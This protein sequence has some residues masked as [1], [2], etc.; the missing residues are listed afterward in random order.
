MYKRMPYG[1]NYASAMGRRRQRNSDISVYAWLLA[2]VGAAPAVFLWRDPHW[3][4]LCAAF[5]AVF[6]GWLYRRLVRFRIER[7]RET[8]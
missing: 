6:Y 1:I 4:M 2:A 5:F 3:L 8:M 7:R